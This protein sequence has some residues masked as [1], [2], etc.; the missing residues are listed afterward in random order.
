MNAQP[1]NRLCAGFCKMH[2]FLA[3][4]DLL[5]P[6]VQRIQR[7]K[8]TTAAQVS[9]LS[10]ESKHDPKLFFSF[11]QHLREKNKNS[12]RRLPPLTTGQ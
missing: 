11:L 4:R 9:S 5:P 10:L 6:F 2:N 7:T 3:T 8:D 12:T 1:Y